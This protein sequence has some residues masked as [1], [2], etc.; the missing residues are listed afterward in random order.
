VEAKEIRYYDA[1]GPIVVT[2]EK[3]IREFTDE[4]LS[5]H[6]TFI[7]TLRIF[8]SESKEKEGEPP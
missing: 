4:E 8:I 5:E 2:P 1:H 7:E 6:L 3:E